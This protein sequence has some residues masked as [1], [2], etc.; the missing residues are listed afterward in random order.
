MRGVPTP[1]GHRDDGVT[2]G[3]VA[4]RRGAVA[5][6]DRAATAGRAHAPTANETDIFAACV[7]RSGTCPRD[8]DVINL[9]IR[10]E[11]EPV[12]ATEKVRV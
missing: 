2:D 5:R 11:S 4:A 12:A 6:V 8:V 10:G 7:W 3:D 9:Y 1:A